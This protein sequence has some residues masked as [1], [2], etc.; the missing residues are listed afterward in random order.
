MD[1]CFIKSIEYTKKMKYKDNFV[2]LILQL[3]ALCKLQK[4]NYFFSLS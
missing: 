2:I 4:L 1:I 3:L